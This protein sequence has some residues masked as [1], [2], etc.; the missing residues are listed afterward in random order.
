M[1]AS[2]PREAT[3]RSGM[4]RNFEEPPKR[5]TDRTALAPAVKKSGGQYKT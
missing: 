2:L 5:R 4:G 3:R 1:N